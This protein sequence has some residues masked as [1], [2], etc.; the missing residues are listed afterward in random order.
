MLV[1]AII[2]HAHHRR[3][4]ARTYLFA[5]QNVRALLDLAES[6]LAQWFT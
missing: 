4:H 1:K 5:R 6:A 3:N 2:G